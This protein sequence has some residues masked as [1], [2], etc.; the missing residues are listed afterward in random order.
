[1]AGVGWEETGWLLCECVGER[2]RES[3]RE[4]VCVQ[5]KC[6]ARTDRQEDGEENVW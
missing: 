1:M 6:M 3:E 2:E 5:T 4:R